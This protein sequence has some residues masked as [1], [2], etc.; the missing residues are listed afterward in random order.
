MSV[1]MCRR[2]AIALTLNPGAFLTSCITADLAEL[3]LRELTHV[4]HFQRSATAN[5]KRS[6]GFNPDKISTLSLACSPNFTLELS[7]YLLP[8]PLSPHSYCFAAPTVPLNFP[9]PLLPLLSSAPAP[10]E[11]WLFPAL[12][13][14]LVSLTQ[15]SPVPA[16]HCHLL[17]A[18]GNHYTQL[19]PSEL[20]VELW[21][22]TDLPSK[23]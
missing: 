14:A 20:L 2:I 13:L 16:V 6:P 18:I 3:F 4:F 15:S 8:S 23:I 7:L 21:E 12:T 9:V 19:V 10:V 17:V 22:M 11:K 1:P 5:D